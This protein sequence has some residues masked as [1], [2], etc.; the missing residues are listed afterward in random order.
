M[1]LFYNHIDL[2]CYF[3]HRNINL[4]RKFDEFFGR[5][6]LECLDESKTS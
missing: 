3:V 5:M 6:T 1:L 2:K 4:F